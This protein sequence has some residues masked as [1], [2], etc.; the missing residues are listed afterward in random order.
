MTPTEL[1]SQE[2]AI[3]LI[4]QYLSGPAEEI[5][6][7]LYR[8]KILASANSYR[9]DLKNPEQRVRYESLKKIAVGEARDNPDVLIGVVD[10][11]GTDTAES[12]AC[13]LSATLGLSIPEAE[14]NLNGTK[15]AIDHE[16]KDIILFLEN[17]DQ[18][19]N[20]T[21]GKLRSF[22]QKLSHRQTRK[23]KF[24]TLADIE[25]LLQRQTETSPLINIFISEGT[26]NDL[27]KFDDAQAHTVVKAFQEAIQVLDKEASA[28]LSLP[29]GSGKTSFAGYLCELKGAP[30]MMITIQDHLK[31]GTQQEAAD[32]SDLPLN[33]NNRLVIIDEAQIL[34]HLQKKELVLRYGKVLFL[35]TIQPESLGDR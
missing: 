7:G 4:T 13:K 26:V 21:A 33:P 25:N 8:Q 34:T 15:R 29:S 10:F 18:L 30:A 5:V 17:I 19:E 28:D 27:P 24:Y 16:G 12:I 2:G 9:Y 23:A 11:V 6:T 14:K 1:T 20:A 31:E 35:N 32:L 3:S 22:L